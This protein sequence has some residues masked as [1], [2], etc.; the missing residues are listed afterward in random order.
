MR[1]EFVFVSFILVSALAGLAIFW[2]PVLW[3]M[4][5]LGPLLA[6]GVQDY[7]Q[8]KHAIRRNYPLL[9]RF[10]YWLEAIRPEINQYFIE[11]NTDGRLFS[12]DERSLVYQ[13]AKSTLDTMPFGTRMDMY[14]S[15]YEWLNHSMAP[16][17][18]DPSSLRVTVGGPDCSKPYSSSV[19]NISAM[20]YGALSG[21]A[22]RALNGG[23]KDGNF[24]HNTGE[25]GISPH[26]LA[27]GGDLIW[28]IG[29][30]YFGCR[31]LHGDF[32]PGLFAANAARP[33]VKMIEIKVSQGAKP[34][35]GGILPAKKVTP[36]I[37]KIRNV[38][39]GQDVLSP[40]AHRAFSTPI[41][42][43]RF[44]AELRELSA[45]K[46]VGFKLCVGKRREFLALCKAMVETGITPD[47]IAVDGAEGGTGAAPVEFTDRVGSPAVE[48][49]IF[50]H[51]ALQGFGL[52]DRIRV[53]GSGRMTTGF[54]MIKSMILGGDMVY[55]ARAM[56]LALGC[57]Q[58]LRC[59]ANDCPAGVAT[60]NPNLAA[61]LVVTDKRRRVAAFHRES[62]SSIAELLGTMGLSQ[63]HELRPWHLMRRV[64]STEVRHYGELYRYLESGEL[65]GE[66]VPDEYARAVIAAT[67]AT[68][69][70]QN[71]QELEAVAPAHSVG[72]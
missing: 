69:G 39:L 28:Q 3:S 68:F 34:G 11:S 43:M 71:E 50:V 8:T 35:H 38:P 70:H 14:Q 61:G 18:V 59:N 22:I 7:V 58:A 64:S 65:L 54:G 62:V 53:I 67:A 23:A 25:G 55:S 72:V 57:I 52:R 13:R 10:R 32:D 33:E 27:M 2:P 24:A 37:A 16:R 51:N 46:P 5:I 31:T 66:Q 48:S 30:G 56:M 4:L 12:R 19:L 26:H 45:G 20:S 36:E 41:E 21:N 15:G 63:S 42:M 17:H 47:F 29:T 9:G 44:I 6:A 60:Q 1:R 40:P 49:I